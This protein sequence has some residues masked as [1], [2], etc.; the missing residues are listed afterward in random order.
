VWRVEVK[1]GDRL[2]NEQIVAVLE[3]MKLEIPVQD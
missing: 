2:E 1:V 3:V